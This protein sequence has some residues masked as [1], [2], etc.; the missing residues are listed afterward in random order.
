MCA[1]L[2]VVWGE[3]NN[4]V[5]KGVERDPGEIWSLMRYHDSL[6]ISNSKAFCNYSI[7]DILHSRHPF[8]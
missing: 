3:E 6:W 4:R 8:L 2:W 1:I 5:F 7:G